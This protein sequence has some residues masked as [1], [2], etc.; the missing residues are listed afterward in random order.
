MWNYDFEC[1]YAVRLANP[2]KSQL[3]C[4]FTVKNNGAEQK[5]QDFSFTSALHAYFT[6]GDI[7]KVSVTASDEAKGLT[8]VRYRDQLQQG[9]VCVEE[10][11]AVTFSG[12]TDRVYLN[13]PNTLLI[14]D[15]QLKR[16]IL[17]EKSGF[18]D[19]VIWNPWEK[20]AKTFSDF[21]A[22]EWP[23]MVCVEASAVGEPISLAPKSTFQASIL[24]SC[25]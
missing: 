14:V 9:K 12:E 17:L 3:F 13:T 20:K 23:K 6:V 24:L 5:G 16:K 21:D 18:K 1:L 10:A 7:T 4:Q 15:E 19:A 25:L 8:G 11:A 22:A 2:R